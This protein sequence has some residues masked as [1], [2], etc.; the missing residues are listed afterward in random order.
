MQNQNKQFTTLIGRLIQ[1]WSGYLFVSVHRTLSKSANWVARKRSWF[2]QSIWIFHYSHWSFTNDSRR[3]LIVV[4]SLSYC[5]HEQQQKNR[6]NTPKELLHN[7]IRP[8]ITQL[9]STN[10]NEKKNHLNT[11][12]MERLTNERKRMKKRC[13]VFNLFSSS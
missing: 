13:Q 3:I 8:F 5:A 9:S 1:S 7:G 4:G 2:G 11:N 6:Q 10:H 12:E